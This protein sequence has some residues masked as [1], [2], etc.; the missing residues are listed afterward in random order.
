[1]C[2]CNCSSPRG[3]GMYIYKMIMIFLG[4]VRWIKGTQFLSDT[5]GK[6]LA[7]HTQNCS[8]CL[9]KER[10]SG[11]SSQG[12]KPKELGKLITASCSI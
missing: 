1:M 11:S 3:T 10:D 12:R 5:C 9:R 4:M 2:A 7:Q 6:V 8:P